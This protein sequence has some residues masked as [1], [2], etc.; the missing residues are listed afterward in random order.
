MISRLSPA[1]FISVAA[2]PPAAAGPTPILPVKA[3]AVT[4]LGAGLV[5]A[6]VTAAT[7]VPLTL[8]I[9]SGAVDPAV[10]TVLHLAFLNG[11]AVALGAVAVAGMA[12]GAMASRPPKADPGAI[13]QLLERP[14]SALR[15]AAA[16]IDAAGSKEDARLAG[17]IGGRKAGQFFGGLAGA[18]QGLYVGGSIGFMGAARDILPLGLSTMAV[19][20]EL[21]IP[22]MTLVGCLAGA[23][24]VGV[25]GEYVGGSI[26]GAVGGAVAEARYRN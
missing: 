21:A 14:A 2:R 3:A 10:H 5:S 7:G 4:G 8:W 17:A 13:R 20:P 15:E 26:G 25:A 16:G 23:I 22:M 12:A 24:V 19:R 9:N 11:A 18:I 6:T 1:R